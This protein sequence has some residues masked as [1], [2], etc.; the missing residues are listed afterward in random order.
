MVMAMI[1]DITKHNILLDL[2][3]TYCFHSL[4]IAYDHLAVIHFNA[5]SRDISDWY[6]C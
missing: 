5:N 6:N 4:R 3:K 2:K 1:K